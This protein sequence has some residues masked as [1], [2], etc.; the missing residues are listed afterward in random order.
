MQVWARVV[1]GAGELV[2]RGGGRAHNRAAAAGTRFQ[3]V[4]GA[5][6]R[7]GGR[8]A[9]AGGLAAGPLGKRRG[10]GAL[11][12]WPSS[13][14]Q[15]SARGSLKRRKSRMMER[16]MSTLQ[17]CVTIGAVEEAGPRPK[18]RRLV[19]G[20]A[21]RRAGRSHE[22]PSPP[23]PQCSSH[24]PRARALSRSLPSHLPRLATMLSVPQMVSKIF[25]MPRQYS[26]T[27]VNATIVFN[28]RG[29]N[30]QRRFHM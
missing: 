24:G 29:G 13:L 1:R 9:R 27:P 30:G 14:H 3:Q 25:Q 18:Q 4:G 22:R 26:M 20:R 23:R 7:A 8:Q 17:A 15:N 16:P 2:Y 28:C 12:P 11:H 21:R 5:E 6:S 19:A 10:G